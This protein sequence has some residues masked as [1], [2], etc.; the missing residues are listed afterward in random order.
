M[1]DIH[2]TAIVAASARIGDGVTIGPYSIVGGEVVLG[3]RVRLRSHVVVD[4]KTTIGA[5][6]D[7]YP[8]AS[9]G[10]AP[11]D[12]GYRD[13][14][15][16]VSVG[17]N[18][19]IREQVTI[20]RG[21]AKGRGRTTV[22]SNCFFMVGSHVAHDC[23]VGDRVTLVNH[24]TIGGHVEVGDYA[25]LGGLSAVQQRLR[26]GAHAFVGGHS[27]IAGD[28]IPFGIGVGRGARLGG[29]N[30]VG[31]KRRGFDRPTIHALRAAYRTIF[32]GTGS[33]LA[34]RVDV[35]A[36]EYSDIPA[37]MMVV[38]FIRAGDGTALC[39]PRDENGD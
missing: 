9:I 26:I 29:L 37:V 31:L 38:N 12:I 14:P 34:E 30:I 7:I 5:G 10:E 19:I 11:Q 33:S 13:E 3:D 22:G 8:F 35:V 39:V 18:C 28:L 6:T 4:G 20:H 15:T 1:A 2:P 24:A 27:G 25:I 36:E 32:F 21:T 17:E 16:E 23:V